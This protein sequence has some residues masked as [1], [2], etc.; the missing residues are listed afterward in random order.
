MARADYCRQ[1][2]LS[3]KTFERWMK[4][5]GKST[6]GSRGRVASDI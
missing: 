2:G 1:H 5:P 4:H 6:A 3:T